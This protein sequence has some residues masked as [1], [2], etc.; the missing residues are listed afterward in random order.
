MNDSAAA[1]DSEKFRLRRFLESL[2]PDEFERREAPIELADVAA[3]L[4]GNPRAVLFASAGPELQPGPSPTEEEK[5][6]TN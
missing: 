4:E 1:L 5:N 2:G 6:S 3:V